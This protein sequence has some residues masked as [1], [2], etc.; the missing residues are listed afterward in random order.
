MRDSEMLVSII[1]PIYNGF[2]Y[3]NK[4]YISLINQTFQ[5][6]EVWF[7]NDGS[8]DN[9]L[10]ILTKIIKKDERIHYFFRSR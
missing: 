9:S 2:K 1:V 6:F 8:Y 7:I 4:L 3:I 5:D 10:E